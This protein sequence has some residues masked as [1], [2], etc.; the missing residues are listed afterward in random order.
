VKDRLSHLLLFLKQEFGQKIPRGT[1]LSVRLTHQDMADA[2][3]T[4]RVT[5]TRLLGKLQQQGMI[6]F[7]SK[8]HIVFNED[9]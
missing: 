6:S 7:D 5:I 4:T 2:C 8:Q 1:R 9:N 3:C